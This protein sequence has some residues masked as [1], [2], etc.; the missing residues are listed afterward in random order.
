MARRKNSGAAFS[1]FSFQDIITS[2]TG[3]MILVTLI[4]AVELIQRV[5]LSP[6]NRTK[7][8][9]NSVQQNVSETNSVSN[10]VEEND[11][12]IDRLQR[13]LEKGAK[14]IEDVSGFDPRQ[15]DDRLSDMIEI[16]EQL[17]GDL[18]TLEK[19][20]AIAD[21]Q[22]KKYEELANTFDP[23]EMQKLIQ[24]IE[25]GRKALADIK[26]NNRVIFNPTDGDAKKPW[27][28]QIAPDSLLAARVAV[29]ERPTTFDN[30][31][32]FRDWVNR[33]NPVSDYIVLLIKPGSNEMFR[34]ILAILKPMKFDL[35]YDLLSAD[36]NAIDANIGAAAL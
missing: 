27:I 35:G 3:I 30:I 36:Q 16:N 22:H 13:E 12:I 23:Q 7:S 1:L 28:V 15:I 10:A 26:K 4:L 24:E 17:A 31:E 33:R 6:E 21:R 32:A 9:T 25:E 29:S 14:S 19:D 2:V 5:E 18:K 11:R 8:V 34:A 20:L